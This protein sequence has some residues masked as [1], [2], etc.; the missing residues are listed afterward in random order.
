MRL[1]QRFSLQ[2]FLRGE[3]AAAGPI[4]LRQRRVFILPTRQGLFFGGLLLTMLLGAVNYNNSLGFTLTFLLASLCLV[5]MLHTYRNLLHLRVSVAH[6]APVFCGDTAQVPVI[7]DNPGTPPRYALQ[8]GFPHQ[9]RH[10]SDVP[11]GAWTRLT[12]P[13]PCQRRG[14]Q[15]LPRITLRSAFPLGVFQAWAHVNLDDTLLVY[16]QPAAPREMP[17]DAR[18]QPDLGGDRGQGSDDF[19]GLRGYHPGDS[20]RHVHWKAAA[21]AQGLFTKQFGGDRAEELWLDWESLAGMETEA[22]LS[23]LT[24]W[25][26]DAEAAQFSYGLRLPGKQIPLGHGAAHRHHCL[27]ML[28]LFPGGAA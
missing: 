4:T 3:D 26:L 7:L 12:L 13:L 6:I 1:A 17:R 24:R 11:A 23:L 5:A 20:L 21:R 8:V 27:Q 2:R 28:A 9:A 25:V 18:M 10:A 15:P 22:R 19:A 14:R 16:P